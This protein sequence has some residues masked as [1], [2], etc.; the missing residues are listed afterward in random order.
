MKSVWTATGL[1][2]IAVLRFSALSVLAAGPAVITTSDA[3]QASAIGNSLAPII[4]PDRRFVVFTSHA[5]NLVT[6]DDLRPHSDIFMRDRV[7]STTTLVSVNADG[8]GGGNGDSSHPGLSTNGQS[9]VFA[10]YANNLVLNDTNRISDVFLR[11]VQNGE[12]LLVSARPDGDVATASPLVSTPF[13]GSSRPVMTPDARWV[14]FESTSHN[15]VSNDTNGIADVFVRDTRRATTRQVSAGAQSPASGRGRSHSPVIADDGSR[16]AFVSTAANI[17]PGRTNRNGDVYV[18]DLQT[19]NTFWASS[20][21]VTYFHNG[22]EG[23]RCFHPVI[24]SDGKHVAFKAVSLDIP[25]VF[26]FYHDLQTGATQL[27]ADGSHPDTAPALSTDSRWFA[28][29][30]NDSIYVRDV[31]KGANLLVSVNASGSGPANGKSL[32]PVVTPDGAHVAFISSATD[33]V[34]TVPPGATN[35]SR[36]YVRDML[37]GVTR[38]VGVATNGLASAFDME[39][40]LPALSADGRLVAFDTDAKDIVS[41]DN[42]QAYDVFTR[43]IAGGLTEL[44]SIGDANLLPRTGLQ[45]A[46]ISRWSL[47]AEARRVAFSAYDD[48]NRVPRD[49]NGMADVFVRDLQTGELF[50]QSESNGVFTPWTAGVQPNISGNGQS[51]LFLRDYRNGSLYSGQNFDLFWRRVDGSAQFALRTNVLFFP[52]SLSLSSQAA[53]SSNGTLVA[54]MVGR[55]ELRDM[56][57]GTNRVVSGAGSESNPQ[58]SPD[59]QWVVYNRGQSLQAT[60]VESTGTILIAPTNGSSL[61]VFSG[62]GRYLGYSSPNRQVY[63][64]DFQTTNSALLCTN[65]GEPSLSDDG[66]LVAVSAMKGST[67]TDIY[68]LDAIHGEMTLIS[69]DYTGNRGGNGASST[70]LISGAGSYVV[71]VSKANNLV[72]NDTNGGADIFV[73]D[74]LQS[75]TMLVTRNRQGTGSGNALS[76]TPVLS[77]DGRTVVFQS[78]AGDLVEGDYNER[79]DIFVLRLGVGDSDNDGMDD[80]WEAAYFNDLSRDGTGDLDGDGQTDRQEFVSGTDPTNKGSLLRVLTVSPMSGG[81]TTILWS[82]VPNRNYVVQFKDSLS[83]ANW[84]NASGVLTAT[85]NSEAFVHPSSALQRYYRVIAVQ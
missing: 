53:I 66:N 49:T 65:C 76:S 21:L 61:P 82:A 54:Y 23:F 13:T 59:E 60:H 11:N 8:L 14:A 64:F 1:A 15:L 19:S 48:H 68:V 72:L 47:D 71:F 32:R 24:S 84:S 4:T 78:F 62:T 26:V 52:G 51:L 50:S 83:A 55:L 5:N 73:H 3:P 9:V 58:F 18:C 79:R 69:R 37:A 80:D 46:T 20:N 41:D 22:P 75:T 10:S 70:P 57:A 6:N 31:E 56:I 85:S 28:F 33:L 42:N 77:R 34:T 29:E 12:T 17:V 35:V 30:R 40:V 38:L 43:D 44:V 2:T 27:I 67:L 45:S 81:N 63:R 25:V 74:R 39:A 7:L 16:I 36:I